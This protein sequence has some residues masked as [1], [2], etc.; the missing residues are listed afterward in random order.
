MAPA[1]I[2]LRNHYRNPIYAHVL[3]SYLVKYIYS[4]TLSILITENCIKL[5]IF[6][7]NCRHSNE[8]ID[9]VVVMVTELLLM[10]SS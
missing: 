9:D 10:S 4:Q 3:F 6:T 5:I 2:N 7:C 1:V 8:I